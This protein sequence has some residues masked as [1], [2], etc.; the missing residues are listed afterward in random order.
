MY[1]FIIKRQPAQTRNP[2]PTPASASCHTIYWEGIITQQQMIKFFTENFIIS[3]SANTFHAADSVWTKS[4]I[5]RLQQCT[6]VF[7]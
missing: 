5:K 3:N 6:A 7:F 4:K 2:C 1:N